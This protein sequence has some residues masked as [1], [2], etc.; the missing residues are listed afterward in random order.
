MTLAVVGA[1]AL[2]DV[3]EGAAVVVLFAL[4]NWFEGQCSLSAR[5]AIA[6]VIALQ[7]DKAVLAA[8]G[9]S[10]P[11]LVVL[12]RGRE[13]STVTALAGSQLVL[14][15]FEWIPQTLFRAC[16]LFLCHL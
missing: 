13:S 10:S 15:A 12:H 4:A 3:I 7:P 11:L 16:L 8:S 1:L 6:A 2:Q 14:S 9:R 5:N